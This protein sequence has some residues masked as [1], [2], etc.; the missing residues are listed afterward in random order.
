MTL[1]LTIA[2]W[3]LGEE[4]FPAHFSE[5]AEGAE[6]VPFHEYLDLDEARARRCRRPLS[7]PSMRNGGWARSASRRE[8]VELAEE[9]LR[10]WA[11]LKELAG[12]E[13]S[14]HMRDAVGEGVTRKLEQQARCPEVRVRGEDREADQPVP[15]ADRAEDRRRPAEGQRQ[16]NRR[17][18]AGEG[19]KLEGSGVQGPGRTRLRGRLEAPKLNPPNR[20]RQQR[21]RLRPLR[22]RPRLK[23]KMKYCPA[24]P[25]STRFAAPP[26]TSAP[27]STTRCSPTTRTGWPTSRIRGRVRSGNWWKR[28]KNVRRRSSTRVN[29]SNPDEKGLDQLIKR[30]EPFN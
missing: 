18:I 17:A 19:R 5:P 11:Q 12:I 16:R 7:T 27:R 15:R 21:H 26:A 4:R 20:K 24:S 3:A 22:L 8:L 25:G 14:D 1:P 23:T 30:A 29:R 13:V 2:D 9:R 6:L 10:Y 28:P